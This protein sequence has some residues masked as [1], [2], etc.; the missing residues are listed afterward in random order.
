MTHTTK[1]LVL[2]LAIALLSTPSLSAAP[3]I[4]GYRLSFDGYSS[5]APLA[6]DEH[7][8]VHLWLAPFDMAVAKPLLSVGFVTPIYGSGPTALLEAS[9]EV[10]L[11]DWVGHPLSGLFRRK[12]ALSPTVGAAVIAPL[13]DLGS[14]TLVLTVHP[15]SFF[16]GEKTVSVLAPRALYAWETGQWSWG[17]RLLEINHA[18]F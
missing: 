14:S 4:G 16:F 11:F 9:L 15:L 7:M 18:L 1:A 13:A 2:A 6:T 5:S 10:R 3:W 12:S 17:I 8:G